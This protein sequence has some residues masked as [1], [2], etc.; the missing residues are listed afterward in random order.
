MSITS[1]IT[2]SVKSIATSKVNGLL[3]GFPG[4]AAL[5]GIMGKAFGK[6]LFHFRPSRL[7]HL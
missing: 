5:N 3:G 4:A 2:S 7:V 6:L 1:G